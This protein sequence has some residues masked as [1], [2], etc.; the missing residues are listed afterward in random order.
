VLDLP[1]SR[2]LRDAETVL[3][4]IEAELTRDSWGDLESDPF[5]DEASSYRTPRN[6]P[7]PAPVP[8][9]EIDVAAHTPVADAAMT[10]FRFQQGGSNKFWR[11]GQQG[12]DVTVVYGRIGTKGQTMVKTFN[13]PQRAQAE[14]TKL[15]LEKTR[16]GYVE[17]D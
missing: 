2:W 17:A 4:R 9:P 7:A 16:K 15:T 3:G 14:V 5:G 12:C 11:I 10:E 6:R 1:V 8:A 13:T